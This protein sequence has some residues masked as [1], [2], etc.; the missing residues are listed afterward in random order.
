MALHGPPKQS[1]LWGPCKA[2]KMNESHLGVVQI[3]QTP[4]LSRT[5]PLW[6]PGKAL[7]NEAHIGDRAWPHPNKVPFQVPCKAPNLNESH[8]KALQGSPSPENESA[9]GGPARHPKNESP[10]GALQGPPNKVS[11]GGCASPK[12]IFH[13]G[14]C[15]GR[16]KTSP[17]QSESAVGNPARPPKMSPPW[18]PCKAPPNK[19]PCKPCKP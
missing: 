16:L 3:S 11:F 2:P 12:Q 17:P 1:L 19:V 4:A 15:A 9:L 5:S 8:F 18:G 6:G 13:F 7:Q 10:L 14:G